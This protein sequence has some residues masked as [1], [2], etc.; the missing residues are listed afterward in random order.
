MSFSWGDINSK[1][2]SVKQHLNNTY[3]K[4]VVVVFP[5][6]TCILSSAHA[7]RLDGL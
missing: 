2:M 7:H 4:F 6:H 3:L 5:I 1:L